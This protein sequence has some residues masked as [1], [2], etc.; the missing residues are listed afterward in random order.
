MSIG[1][2]QVGIV[3]S[4]DVSYSKPSCFGS[5]DR[6]CHEDDSIVTWEMAKEKRKHDRDEVTKKE[7]SLKNLKVTKL[8]AVRIEP[9]TPKK[10]RAS[11]KKADKTDKADDDAQLAADNADDDAQMA[12]MAADKAEAQ[13]AADKAD[14]DTA[15][16]AAADDDFEESHEG[17]LGGMRGHLRRCRLMELGVDAD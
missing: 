15:A 8:L 13:M 10:R 5:P 11:T 4:D 17:Q 9:P 6:S 1:D 2:V 7:A 3:E 14:A 16:A 12:Q